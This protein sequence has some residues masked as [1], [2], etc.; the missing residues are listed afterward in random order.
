[1]LER[2][3]GEANYTGA[4]GLRQLQIMLITKTGRGEGR[5]E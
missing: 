2:A 3:L 4:A 1:M 5:A